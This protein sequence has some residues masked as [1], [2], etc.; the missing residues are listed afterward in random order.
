MDKYK[1]CHFKFYVSVFDCFIEFFYLPNL[2][3][4]ILFRYKKYS[5]MFIFGD[6]IQSIYFWL[7]LFIYWTKIINCLKEN[8][9]FGKI[10]NLYFLLNKILINELN[11]TVVIQQW[12]TD[13]Q[14]FIDVLILFKVNTHSQFYY[15]HCCIEIIKIFH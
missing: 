14:V 13:H 12:K 4:I 5:C 8:E 10:F 6:T 11:R 1:K 15:F 9:Y 2:F 3:E 7:W